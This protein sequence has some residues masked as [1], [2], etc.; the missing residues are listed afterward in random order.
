MP[1]PS[2]SARPIS[3]RSYMHRRRRKRFSPLLLIVMLVG[4]VGT[5]L[6]FAWPEDLGG[7]GETEAPK[8]NAEGAERTTP[9]V[10]PGDE[11]DELERLAASDRDTTPP[12]A[13]RDTPVYTPPAARTALRDEAPEP[14]PD[15]VR[16][17][18]VVTER[19]GAAPAASARAMRLFEQ[20]QAHLD[21]NEPLEARRA[22]TAA[23]ATESLD[24]AVAE[25]ARL[26]L[27]RLNEDLVFG[28][29]IIEDDPYTFVYRVQ[30]NDALARLPRKLG[31]QIDWRL[32]KRINRIERAS[33]LQR[34]QPIKVVT[35]PFHA[36]VHKKDYRMDVY[37][38]EEGDRVYV[39][40]FPVG[41]GEYNS[42]P[43]GRFRVRPDSKL[44]NPEW[45]NPRTRE[46]YR[47]DDPLNPIGEHWIG[48]VADDPR[49]ANV[50]GYGIHGT[51]EPDSIGRQ[52]SMGCVRMR[53]ED[54]ALVYE[55]LIEDASTI[56]IVP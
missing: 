41:L 9:G 37:L 25:E 3:R 48:L 35:G 45:R 13:A 28:P 18:E 36:V 43:E 16:A 20:G 56:M 6:Y 23:L 19:P 53:S 21:R 22:I 1:L 27:T 34:D 52:A 7:G 50:H 4:V 47:A 31:L 5:A 12:P 51:I 11:D 42:T 30:P 24:F 2:Q 40:S 32:L 10:M 49:L 44:I 33:S 15:P 29:T 39:R 55:L 14:D 54:V 26:A 46:L 38:G 8:S 17:A